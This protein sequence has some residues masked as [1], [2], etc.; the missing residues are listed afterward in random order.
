M[1]IVH[2]RV[3]VIQ[4]V[5]SLL[6]SEV[7]KFVHTCT[8]SLFPLT[9]NIT[10]YNFDTLFSLPWGKLG[11]KKNLL[12]GR[13]PQNGRCHGVSSP[14]PVKFAQ[15]YYS[16]SKMRKIIL[17]CLNVC[18]YLKKRKMDVMALNET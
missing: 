10:V 14:Y 11:H 5:V 13:S 12:R 1:V 16:K 18:G 15:R 2:K 8:V 3:D 4:R 17:G 7:N 6:R 9:F